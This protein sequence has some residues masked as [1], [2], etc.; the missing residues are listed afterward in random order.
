[1]TNYVTELA[2]RLGLPANGIVPGPTWLT[3]SLKFR[4]DD[5]WLSAAMD[6]LTEMRAEHPGLRIPMRVWDDRH[7]LVDAFNETEGLSA[8]EMYARGWTWHAGKAEKR[9]AA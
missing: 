9:K 6:V 7:N 1:M 8:E 4:L 2:A 3:L 5:E